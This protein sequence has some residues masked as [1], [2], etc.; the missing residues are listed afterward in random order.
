[1]DRT[2]ERELLERCRRGDRDAYEPIVRSCEGRVL[3]LLRGLTGDLDEARDLA[4][5]SFLRAYLNLHR[6]DLDRP[7][8]PWLLAIARRLF[9]DSRRRRGGRDDVRGFHEGELQRIPDSAGIGDASSGTDGGI[10]GSET[11]KKKVWSALGRLSATQ[12]EVLVLKD[13]VELSYAEIASIMGIP[14]GTV[15]SRVYKARRSLHSELAG[16][17]E[18]VTRVTAA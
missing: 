10:E 11:V 7:F 14:I 17:D 2:E 5:D 15:A 18:E 9:L 8:L 1:M 16:R 4:Q 6:Y 3:G 13:I 12:R